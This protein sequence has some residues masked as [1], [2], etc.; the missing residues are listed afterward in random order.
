MKRKDNRIQVE[1]LIAKISGKASPAWMSDYQ[2]LEI[3][4]SS[5][6]FAKNIFEATERLQ[7]WGLKDQLRRASV[8]I[9]SNIAEG[10]DRGSDREFVRFLH[11]AKGS[12]AECRTQLKIAAM[13]GLISQSTFDTLEMDAISLNK[14]ISA[15][16]QYLRKQP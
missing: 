5:C 9:A 16:I 2:K 7:D 8:S 1:W 14:R 11:I 10:S 4:E 6:C 13:T 12:G 15:L 3:W